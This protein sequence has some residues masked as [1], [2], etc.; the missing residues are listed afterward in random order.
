[1]D[2][3]LP[4]V[5]TLSISGRYFS[6]LWRSMM[7]G[8][9]LG[10]RLRESSAAFTLSSKLTLSWNVRWLFLLKFRSSC[11]NFFS[12]NSSTAV[13]QNMFGSKLGRHERRFL[14]VAR[15]LVSF[16]IGRY[17]NPSPVVYHL[18]LIVTI[19]MGLR[20]NGLDNYLFKEFE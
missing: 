14:T 9:L 15:N 2:H 17:V 18:Y 8:T 1:M 5:L 19:K 11:E 6:D 4:L 7:R 10:K 16:K 13:G 20:R 12:K 3:S